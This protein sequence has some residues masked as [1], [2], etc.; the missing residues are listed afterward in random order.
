M[1]EREVHDREGLSRRR[2][3]GLAAAGVA[4]AVLPATTA[5]AQGVAREFSRGK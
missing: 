1:N 3:L 2:F 5:R 4:V